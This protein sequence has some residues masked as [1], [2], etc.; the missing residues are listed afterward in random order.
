M[1]SS[2]EIT[3]PPAPAPAPRPN[4]FAR[5]AGLFSHPSATMADVADR[6]DWVVPLLLIV[7]VS[8]ALN[9]VAA[10]R[11]DLE[12]GMREQF[13]ERGMTDQQADDAIDRVAAFQKFGAP[14]SA[15][16]VAIMLIALAALFMLIARLFGGEG[17]FR[18]YFAVTNYAWLPQ[19]VKGALVVLLLVRAGSLEPDEM[20]TLLKSNLGFLADPEEQ[21][22]LVAVLSSIDLFNIACL[23]LMSFGYGR[24]SRLGTRKMATL[25]ISTYAVW[26]LVRVGIAAMRG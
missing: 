17:V 1:T 16:T 24:A 8:A 6:P 3:P 13:A 11:M 9:F 4:F 18:Q 12:T 2:A 25:V 22:V 10:P 14:I 21:P 23:A 5:I 20:G 15:I 19:L 7:L 26:I